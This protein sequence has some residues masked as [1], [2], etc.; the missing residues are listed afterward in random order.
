M[1]NLYG[2]EFSSRLLIGS[3]LYPSPAIM[4]DA[5]RAAG[6]QIVTVSLRRE[7]AGGKA[8][9]AFWSL[10]RELGV[11]VL[12]NTAGCRGVRDAVT[13]AKLARELFGTSWIKL[14]VIAD[15]D[16]LQPDVVGLV[17]AATILIK[18]GFEVFPYC[19]EDLSV[20]LRLVDAGCRVVMPWAAPIGSARGIVN[21]DALKLLRD[22]LPDITLVVD[23]GLGAPSHAAAAMEL[24]FD[25]VLLNTAIAKAEDPVAMASAFNLAVDAGRIGYQAGL[26]DARD[27]A[28][29]STPV[30]GTPFWHAVS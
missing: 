24:G 29:P 11:T 7:A 20:A 14:E 12:P 10:I 23:A 8:G 4:Q 27:F 2:K 3:A 21:R 5:I 25:A 6:A 26:M 28:S 9:D 19:T 30:I 22:R 18:D 13:T 15:N 1:L 17:E 16:T